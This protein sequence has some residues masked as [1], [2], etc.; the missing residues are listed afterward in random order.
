MHFHELVDGVPV[1]GFAVGARLMPL[2]AVIHEKLQRHR[3]QL[4]VSRP[5]GSRA[6]RVRG[7]AAKLA[8][9]QDG[10]RP[11]RT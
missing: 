3:S 4:R 9:E 7:E 8:K 10:S 6:R 2:E 5:P 11:R 1:N